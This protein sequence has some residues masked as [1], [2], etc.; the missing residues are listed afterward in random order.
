M[1]EIESEDCVI[2]G[3]RS[4]TFEISSCAIDFVDGAQCQYKRKH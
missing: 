2:I 4:T 1:Y 3:G